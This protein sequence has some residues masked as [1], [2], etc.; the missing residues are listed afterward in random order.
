MDI[1]KEEQSTIEQRFTSTGALTRR[2]LIEYIPIMIVT[3]MSV[4][5]LSTVDGLVAGNLVGSEALAS[6][7][8]FFPAILIITVLSSVVA[9]GA[10]TSLSTAMGRNDVEGIRYTKSAVRVTM[11]VAAVFNAVIEFPII[12]FVVNSYDLSPAVSTMVW[13]YATGMM[14]AMPLGLISSVGSYQLQILGRMRVLMILSVIEGVLNLAL[15]LFFAGVLDMGI[16]GIGLGTAGANLFRCTITVIYLI[17]KTDLFRCGGVKPRWEEIKDIL[18]CGAPDAASMLMI[19]I[20]NYFIMM[21]ILEGFGDEGGVIKGVCALSFNIANIITLGMTSSMRPLAG[22]YSGVGNKR[23]LRLL[24]RHCVELTVASV[25]VIVVAME[26]FPRLL[27]QFNGVHDIPDGGI[28][29]LRLFML[30][31][32]FYGVDALFRLYFVNRKDSRYSTGMTIA[33]NAML[34]VFALILLRLLPAPYL[35]LSYLMMETLLLIVNVCRY[36]WW[37]KRDAQEDDPAEE[38]LYLTVK[39][40]DAIEASRMIRSFAEERGYPER[41]AYR[42]ALCMEEMVAYAVKSQHN[43]GV[44]IQIMAKFTPEEG[45]FFMLDDGKCIA[46]DEDREITTLITDNYELVKKLAKSVDYQYILNM[47]YTVFRF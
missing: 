44:E 11:I 46:L 30:Y 29:S 8:I 45:L 15:D 38:V 43:P 17:K 4:F 13:Q 34:P 12:Y 10:A 25:G 24:M 28:L 22:L 26:I 35:W 3:N 19:A 9:S 2:K 37:L 6:V 16:L 27:Y 39:P 36:G 23:Q 42:M 18:Q 14:I 32:V 7:N 21:I 5:L 1:I 41:I 33:G 47:N 31:L 20:Q 40:E